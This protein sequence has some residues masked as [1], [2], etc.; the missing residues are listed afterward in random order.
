MGFSSPLGNLCAKTGPSPTGQASHA[1][2]NGK[3]GL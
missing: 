1:T 3:L 2:T